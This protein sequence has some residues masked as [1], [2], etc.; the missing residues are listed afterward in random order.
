MCF[1]AVKERPKDDQ[2]SSNHVG[3]ITI[4]CVKENTILASLHLLVLLCELFI[5]VWA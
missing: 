4:N 1:T 5:N 3:V 2:D